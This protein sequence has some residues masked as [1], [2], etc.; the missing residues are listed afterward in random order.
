MV[1]SLSEHRTPP[2][3]TPSV[4]H[5]LALIATGLLVLA[6]G[7]RCAPIRLT[8][9]QPLLAG[10]VTWLLD[11]SID[12]G[13]PR[14]KQIALAAALYRADRPQALINEPSAG[15]STLTGNPAPTGP[16]SRGAP[17]DM[18][19]VDV[20]VHDYRSRS[21]QVSSPGYRVSR[22]QRPRLGDRRRT[23]RPRAC[24]RPRRGVRCATPFRFF[25]FPSLS[26]THKKHMSV[27]D[28]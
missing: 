6:F 3:R 19:G 5:L 16:T 9:Q 14:T 11:A 20:A 21:V 27:G 12:L 13:P 26:S 17:A 15:A 7:L 28:R 8:D 4:P 1:A 10:P 25:S 22:K 2:R 24:W 23:I 18:A